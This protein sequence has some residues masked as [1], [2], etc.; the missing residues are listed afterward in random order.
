MNTSSN[1]PTDGA[2]TWHGSV[3]TLPPAPHGGFVPAPSPVRRP[4]A[5]RQSLRAAR[6]LVRGVALLALAALAALPVSAQSAALLAGDRAPLLPDAVV[7]L[8]S[9]QAAGLVRASWRFRAAELVPVA[10][11]AAGQD[12]RPSGPVNSTFDLQP[13]A[14][15]PG[16]DDSGWEAIDPATL[17]D[18]RGNGR[19]SFGW[20]RL[21]FSLPEQLGALSVAGCSAVLEVVV[22]DYAEI[23]VDGRQPLVLGQSGGA[24]PKGWNA[25]NRVLLGHGLQPGRSFEIAVLAANAPLGKPPENYV[26]IRS[27]TL[28]VYAPGRLHAGSE[29]PLHV[30]R[31]AAALDAVVPP[32]SRLEQIAGG[33]L[34][35]EGPQ[36]LPDGSLLFSDPNANVIYRW[37]ESDGVSIYRTK[38]GYKG[39]DIG[40]YR[41]PGSNG[42][43]LDGQ[44]RLLICEHGNRRLTRLEPHGM[45]T[46]LADRYQ[47]RRLNSP[48]D[49][50]ALSDG[51]IVFTD[52]P[53]GLPG[54][55]DDP[56]RELPFT[57]VFG[58]R[59][60]VLSLLTDGLQ[61]PNGVDVSPD[62]RFLY[63]TNWDPQKK[64]VMRYERLA[65]GTL[66]PGHVFF[67]MGAAPQEEAL[68]GLEVDAA[69]NLFVSGPG[70]VW[71]L[72]PQ[73]EQLGML[74]TPELPANFAWGPDQRTLFL[75]ARSGLY[76]LLLGA[77]GTRP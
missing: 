31:L 58:L 45:L 39:L 7:D 28:D 62:E 67:D 18:R 69:G 22:D 77:A 73:G 16:F 53:F 34:F 50:V 46:V 27:A 25:P 14:G 23:W 2:P 60:G 3:P 20:Y 15:A 75:T 71:V 26:W 8:G 10:F 47:G 40:R 19:L 4:S 24:L 48:N 55:H 72:S 11:H 33:F 65:D 9:P 21:R 42:L 57:G 64:V 51:T 35:T 44:G 38:S 37:S 70:G 61:G 32:G 66:G 13:F 5:P 68:D 29:V 49:V 52:P 12:R 54:F 17:E 43:G 74:H 1:S 36:W 30:E 41:Q 76:R 6:T 56:A 59:D 63:V